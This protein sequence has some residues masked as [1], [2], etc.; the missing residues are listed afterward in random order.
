MKGEAKMRHCWY[1]GAELGVYSDY[2]RLDT[3]GKPECLREVQIALAQERDEA[4]R[5]LD[6]DRGWDR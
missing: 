4:H 3:C 1:C 2:D 6:Q 5:Q